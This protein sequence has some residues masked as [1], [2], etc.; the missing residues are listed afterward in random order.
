MAFWNNRAGKLNLCPE[1][2]TRSKGKQHSISCAKGSRK[3][4]VDGDTGACTVQT[5]QILPSQEADLR[6]LWLTDFRKAR[7]CQTRWGLRKSQSLAKSS[8]LIA[9]VLTFYFLRKLLFLFI[10]KWS[11]KNMQLVIQLIQHDQYKQTKPVSF[12]D[13]WRDEGRSCAQ[14]RSV[15][16]PQCHGSRKV[17]PLL[18]GIEMNSSVYCKW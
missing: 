18:T 12:S 7:Q 14:S 13:T 6:Q 11:Y 4:L 3:W 10:G 16:L 17:T 1:C 9:F 5:I 2:C 8:K 15:R